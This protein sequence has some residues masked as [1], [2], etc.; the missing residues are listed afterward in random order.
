MNGMEHAVRIERDT[1]C[2]PSEDAEL[3]ERLQIW[4][5]ISDISYHSSID[6]FFI[7]LDSTRLGLRSALRGIPFIKVV[8]K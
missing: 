5:G 8:D 2:S 7:F 1:S 6:G 4:T 3:M